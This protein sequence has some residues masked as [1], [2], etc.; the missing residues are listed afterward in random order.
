MANILVVGTAAGY[1]SIFPQLLPIPW[2][3]RIFGAVRRSHS[4]PPY[5]L[6]LSQ[7]NELPTAAIF[8][9]F[10][11]K[12]KQAIALLQILANLP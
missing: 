12:S 10:D 7:N 5:S 11:E 8:I 2:L 4:I 1:F 6:D 9:K 3:W